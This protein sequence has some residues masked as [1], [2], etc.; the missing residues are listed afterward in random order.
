[1]AIAERNKYLNQP[2][3]QHDQVWCLIDRDEFP[4][5]RF[6]D[7][8]RL[9]A[10]QDIHVAY[11]IESFELW[12][13]LRFS[14]FRTEIGREAYLEK[15]NSYFKQ[16]GYKA[17]QKNDKQIY[18]KLIELQPQALRNAKKLSSKY[19]SES[20]ILKHDPETTVDQLVLALN[21]QGK[22]RFDLSW[23]KTGT[24]SES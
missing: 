17:Y 23:W 20:D 22:D 3:K 4:E 8:L 12:F 16:H 14:L 24:A 10:K 21:Y 15:L 18:D 11:S 9:A 5:Q 6:R 7:A 19:A 1:M 2:E 13:V